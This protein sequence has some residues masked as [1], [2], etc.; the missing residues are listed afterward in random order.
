MVVQ[1]CNN[2]LNAFTARYLSNV[3]RCGATEEKLPITFRLLV[4]SNAAAEP[5]CT[6]IHPH[7]PLLRCNGQEGQCSWPTPYH[8][9][10][11]SPEDVYEA[12]KVMALC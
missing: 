11:G 7:D 8:A 4:I 2:G 12:M 10:D 3:D 5:R 1:R 6:F 9:L